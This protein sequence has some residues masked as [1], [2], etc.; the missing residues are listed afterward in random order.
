[1]R[2]TLRDALTSVALQGVAPDDAIARAQQDITDSVQRY[3]E[4]GF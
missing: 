2:N 4:G 3:S 1:V